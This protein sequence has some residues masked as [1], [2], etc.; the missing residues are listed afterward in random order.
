MGRVRAFLWH[1]RDIDGRRRGGL[2]PAG[3]V[4]QLRRWLGTRGLALGGSVRIP[5]GLER[6]CVSQTPQANDRQIN[7]LLRQLA[8]LSRAGVPLID[9]VTLIAREEKH[10]GLR[11][12]ADALREAIAAGTPLSIAL[13]D[14]PRH[15]DPLICGLVRAGEQSGQLDTLLERIASDRERA[16]ALRHRLRHA[17]LY[18]GIVLLVALAVSTAL[19]MFVVP[20]FESLF[21]GFGAELPGF[22]RQ[23]IGLSDWL[24]G[25]GW[26]ALLAA[27][28]AVPAMLALT[29]RYPTVRE[30][31]DRIKLAM[32]VTG[33]LIAGAE[34]VRF[35]RTLALLMEAGAPLA[36]ALPTVADTLGTRPY[37][38]AVRRM[39]EDL[40]DGRSLAFAIE[41][42]RCFAATTTRM[43]ATGE[44]AGRLP[45]VLE[46]IA[47]RRDAEVRQ[48]VDTL[49]STLEPL[50]MSFLGLLVGGLVLALYLPVFQLGSVI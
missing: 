31:G 9:A 37:K 27:L 12:L 32:P 7:A 43:I 35:A 44:A 24:R 23:V 1:G 48:G 42:T 39:G 38:R 22:T 14:H 13:A 41:R 30:V 49:G 47:D 4:E 15:F 16:E 28:G 6:L 50:I 2:T 17:M 36:E 20:R 46:R 26:P 25:N 21:N 5:A 29:R 10:A 40:R 34:T 33:G 45:A 3:D 18:P 19:L 11:R 8:T